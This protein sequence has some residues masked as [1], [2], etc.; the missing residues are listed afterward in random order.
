MADI[1]LKKTDI[2]FWFSGDGT[3]DVHIGLEDPTKPLPAT[4]DDLLSV[5]FNA[6]GSKPLSIGA[7][8]SFKFGIS[9]GAKASLTPLWSSSSAARLKKLD[10]YGLKGY[11]SA[12][13]PHNDRVLMILNLGA[14]ADASVEAK[15]K[16]WNLSA[17]AQLEAGADG[18]YALVRSFPSDTPAGN[19][20]RDLF[21]GVRLPANVEE[22]LA[23]D[24][25][26]VFEYGG[27]VNFKG[28]IGLG[29]EI[30]G[31]PSF[32][33]N[34]LNFVEKYKLSL[35][36]SVGLESRLAGRFKVEVRKGSKNGWNHIILRKSRSKF[37]SVA[38]DVSVLAD[39]EQEG[40]PESADDFLSAVIGLKSKNWINLFQQVQAL[41][42]FKQLEVY[43]DNLAKSFIEKYTG[44]A[45]EELADKT[46]LDEALALVKKAVDAYNEVGD[47]AVALFD[48]YFD[49]ATGELDAKLVEALDFVKNITSLDQ[50]KGEV[51]STVWDVVQHLTDGDPLEWL[52]GKI[53]VGGVSVNSLEELKR[54]ADKIIDLVQDE[55]HRKIRDLIGLA[56][57]QFPL[58]KFIKELSG[59]DWM[60]LKTLGD[61]R[62]VGFVERLIGVSVEK[63]SNSELGE[64][65][66]RFHKVLGAI[67]KFKDTLYKK[68]REAL[69][70]SFSFKL[71]AAYSR[72]TEN[73]ALLDFELN[74]TS[75][76]GKEL[77]KKAGQGDFADVLAA[78][79]SG[80]VV[81][82]EGVLSHKVTKESSLSVNI[83]GWH[84]GWHYQAL[85]R[86]IIDAEQR[87]I[88][89]EGQL[90]V[91]TTMTMQKERE[92]KRNGER[93]YT[94]L[95]L[96]FI[97]E[98]RGVL[99]FDKSNQTYL[100]DA[101][102]GI[103]SSYEL[104]FQDASTTPQELARYLS[105][106]DDFG[107]ASS[108][109]AAEAALE[110]LLPMDAQ[111]NFGETSI[112][113]KVRFTEEG[114]KALFNKPFGP[115]DEMFMRR[116][117]RLLVL[118][119]YINKGPFLPE[120]AWCYWTPGIQPVWA[121]GPTAFT[122]HLSLTFDPIAPSPFKNLQ[123]P[124]SVTLDRT[125]LHQLGTLYGIERDIV[126]G[127]RKLSGLVQSQQKLSPRDFE[128]ALDDFGSA[129]SSYDNFDQGDNTIF[130]LFDRLIER[131]SAGQQFRN[132]S[133]EL[134]SKLNGQSVTKMLIA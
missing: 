26:Y 50:L 17:S 56:K 116:T 114:L 134:K 46:K 43:L 131:E 7:S 28:S 4:D 105:F 25:I 112:S 48:K 20:V 63:L 95:L 126:N 118:A 37:F 35:M 88:P 70:Q 84:L 19:L 89:D 92:R 86:L 82:N 42:D 93:I 75:A 54:R 34:Q 106:A 52:L 60:K 29:Y 68:M 16:Y 5:A 109:D 133:L 132:S 91:V 83:V 101:I 66:N 77:M 41:T 122:N 81:L 107:L 90:T 30:S 121:Q 36:A 76:L 80:A 67:D 117:L 85:D 38:A 124:S 61:K 6:S 2:P 8:D 23:E 62:L 11:F 65:V 74:L 14:S 64:A 111:G 3:L 87:I 102:K 31:A 99:N 130:A 15:F 33:I 129:L 39:F 32:E 9:A 57:S 22:P 128:N 119:N 125:N 72:A 110:P 40:L 123:A 59:L 127:M 94:N 104:V 97:G 73:D 108:D 55:G 71:H 96:R 45:F 100:V 120:R 113:Y 115:A 13:S 58:D 21:R 12:G 53:E 78:Y 44:K 69:T 10:D 18:S 103:S 49:A 24:E 51:D 79:G 1:N 47:R 27:Y 98:S